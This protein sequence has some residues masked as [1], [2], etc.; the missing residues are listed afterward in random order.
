MIYFTPVIP[1]IMKHLLQFAGAW[2]LNDVTQQLLP[3][4]WLGIPSDGLHE[5]WHKVCFPVDVKTQF[6]HKSCLESPGAELPPN[7]HTGQ[8]INAMIIHW[9]AKSIVIPVHKKCLVTNFQMFWRFRACEKMSR[10]QN[11][12]KPEYFSTRKGHFLSHAPSRT[13]AEPVCIFSSE[14]SYWAP[15]AWQGDSQGV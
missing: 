4:F 14:N 5:V 3:L 10:L 1:W 8:T 6:P 7:R 13:W 2:G 15:G 11:H 9:P 12:S